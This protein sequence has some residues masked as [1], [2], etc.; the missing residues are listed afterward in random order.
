[1]HHNILKIKTT[2]ST[3][4]AGSTN[5][6]S[7]RKAKRSNR[8]PPPVNCHSTSICSKKNS[9]SLMTCSFSKGW[10]ELTRYLH[11]ACAWE[12][13]QFSF[14]FQKRKQRLTKLQDLHVHPPITSMRQDLRPDVFIHKI[15]SSLSSWQPPH[16]QVDRSESLGER[17]CSYLYRHNIRLPGTWSVLGAAFGY[18]LS[19]LF[20]LF[21][22]HLS[23]Y[24]SLLFSI[25]THFLVTFN[26]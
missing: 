21:V 12:R 14:Y 2:L 4:P 23:F 10:G 3:F 13:M 19:L 9:F 26:K 17:G 5:N 1:M 18:F 7:L 6:V 11:E 15:C 8:P 16:A 24:I 25:S 20:L 22:F